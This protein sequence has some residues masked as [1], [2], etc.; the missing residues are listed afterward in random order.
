M[1]QTDAEALEAGLEVGH[2]GNRAHRLLARKRGGVTVVEHGQTASQV[3]ELVGVA[4]DVV[5]LDLVV[6][7]ADELVAAGPHRL[8]LGAAGVA[9]RLRRRVLLDQELATVEA[10]RVLGETE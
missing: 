5:E 1:T 10:L 9:V 3:L 7:V 2:L 8:V 4:A 6:P